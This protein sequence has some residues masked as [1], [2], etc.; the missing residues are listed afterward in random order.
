V[1][2]HV[3]L[4]DATSQRL[5]ELAEGLRRLD[6]KLHRAATVS[7]AE[8]VLSG[9]A[10]LAL[11]AI[12]DSLDRREGVAFVNSVK[13]QHP[14]LPVLWVGADPSLPLSTFGERTPDLILEELVSSE[15]VELHAQRLLRHQLYPEAIVDMARDRASA[16]L[17]SAFA[18]DLEPGVPCLRANRNTLAPVSAILSFCGSGLSGRIVVSGTDDHLA[19]IFRR[20]VKGDSA[21]SERET[22]DLAGEIANQI[23]GRIKEYFT[24]QGHLFG[25]TSPVYL[26]GDVAVRY[27]AGRPSLVIPFTED[28]GTLFLEFCIDTF[29][30]NASTQTPGEE[31]DD[32]SPGGE[33]VF[34]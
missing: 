3:L 1:R 9:N 23:L 4:V 33:L 18:S 16:V 27:K 28:R 30:P 34:L 14:D 26:R 7:D 5:N 8:R 32:P 6:F 22:E 20:I 13:S 10:L 29:D 19:T 31:A 24:K 11:V 15:D 2:T 25:I 17:S 12:D 21:V